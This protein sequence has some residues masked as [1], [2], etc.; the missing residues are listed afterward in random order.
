MRP[1][2]EQIGE[3]VEAGSYADALALLDIVDVTALP[4]KV[5]FSFMSTL[6]LAAVVRNDVDKAAYYAG[7]ETESCARTARR[8]RVQS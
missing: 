1:W 4:D 5:C 2:S 8:I 3:L 6:H 7:A